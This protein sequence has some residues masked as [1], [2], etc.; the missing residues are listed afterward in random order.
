M[1]IDLVSTIKGMPDIIKK[2]GKFH[3]NGEAQGGS[4]HNAKNNTKVVYCGMVNENAGE[5]DLHLEDFKFFDLG[6]YRYIL[7]HINKNLGVPLTKV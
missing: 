6:F 3:A 2:S 1:A 4:A 5:I 7:T